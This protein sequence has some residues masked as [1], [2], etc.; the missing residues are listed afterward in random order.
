MVDAV[1]LAV[2]RGLL[3]A[4][5]H[6]EGDHRRARR[7]PGRCPRRWGPV[8]SRSWASVW[9]VA[10]PAVLDVSALLGQ[11]GASGCTPPSGGTRGS[12][13][14]GRRTRPRRPPRQASRS[15]RASSATTRSNRNSRQQLLR[16]QAE[17][18][19]HQRPQL[20]RAQQHVGGQVLDPA[21]AVGSP[22][23]A[24]RPATAPGVR[25]TGA[26]RRHGGAASP[27]RRRVAS[28]P[29]HRLPTRSCSSRA[30]SRAP[31][32]RGRPVRAAPRPD[33]RAPTRGER[34]HGEL[35]A[36][37]GRSAARRARPPGAG[38]PPSRRTPWPA[39][40]RS[41][42]PPRPSPTPAPGRRPRR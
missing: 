11:P 12:G 3:E 30:A 40:G 41:R 9:P 19:D 15:P 1:A 6:Q 29:V 20:A 27:A 33:T 5:G 23:R 32:G 31:R 25:R 18:G 36:R 7:G 4:Q 21:A 42:H 14:S 10:V 37:P 13:G 35:D 24:A 8:R 38:R 28:S 34:V 39:P 2:H 22:A 26:R 16:R 17:L